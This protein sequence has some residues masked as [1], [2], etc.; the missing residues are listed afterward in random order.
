MVTGSCATRSLG[1]R[2]RWG[3]FALTAIAV[4]SSAFAQAP[5]PAMPASV[6]PPVF[7][8][9][10]FNVTGENPLGDAE[11]ARVLAP[12]VRNDA[13]LDTLQQASAAL[14]KDLRDHGF[15]LHR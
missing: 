4:A 15:G 8:I 9:K 10:G 11:T 5:T 1:G 14:E 2:V 13:T 6:P 3:L 7:A 12:Y